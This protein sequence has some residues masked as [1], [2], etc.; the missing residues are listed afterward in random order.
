MEQYYENLIARVHT[1]LDCKYISLQTF[2]SVMWYSTLFKIIR[3]EKLFSAFK[4]SQHY[5]LTT[6]CT[7]M[8]SMHTSLQAN[9]ADIKKI[10]E[11]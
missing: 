11:I 3:I 4:T 7:D 6:V 10:I 9:F 2:D 8:D 5:Q 1:E